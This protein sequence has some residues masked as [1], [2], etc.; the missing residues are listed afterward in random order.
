MNQLHQEGSASRSS[1]LSTCCFEKA[2]RWPSTAYVTQEDP[3]RREESG[4]PP[5][6]PKFTQSGLLSPD[7]SLMHALLQH[8]FVCTCLSGLAFL[9]MNSA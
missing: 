9:V 8:A 6:P 5:G 7:R 1:F 3:K 2:S 4:F